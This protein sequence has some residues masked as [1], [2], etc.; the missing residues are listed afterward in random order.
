M[1]SSSDSKRR[2]VSFAESTKNDEKRNSQSVKALSKKDD[3]QGVS[4]HRTE[5]D[6]HADQCCV[7]DYAVVL[8][9]WPDRTVEITPFLDTLGCVESAPIV[10][11]LLAYDDPSTGQAKLL[12]LHQAILIKGLK[13]NLVCPMQLR[14]SGITVNERP[15]HCTSIPTQ[16]DHAIVFE[17]ENYLIS[18]QLDG[19]TSYFPT[20]T[21]TRTEVEDYQDGG[22]FR[23]LTTNSPEWDPHSKIFEDLES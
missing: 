16:E 11:A 2:R 23:E 3:D 21:P 12:V 18:L 7:G 20:R 4:E 9:E 17:D 19:V 14:H 1:S 10:T 22:D 8:Y 15:K 13:H 6:S 5:L